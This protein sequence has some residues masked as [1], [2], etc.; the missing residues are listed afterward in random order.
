VLDSIYFLDILLNFLKRTMACKDLKSIALN[1]VSTT[2]IPDVLATVP[3]LLFLREQHQFFW[4][5]LCRIVHFYHLTYPLSFALNCAL[6]K[7]SKKRQNDLIVFARLILI[8]IYISHVMAC[9]WLLLGDQEPCTVKKDPNCTMSWIY[10]NGFEKK[11]I[12]T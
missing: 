4:F 12:P 11:S 3:Q 2:F 6:Q 7:Y 1:Y 5:K 9:I 10:M 8:V